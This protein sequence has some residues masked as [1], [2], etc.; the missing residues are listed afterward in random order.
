MT[1]IEA[2]NVT[3]YCKPSTLENGIPQSSAFE[4]RSDEKYLSVY[5]LEFFGNETEV[6]NIRQVKTYMEQRRFT[7]K[8]NGSFAILN[9]QQSKEYIYEEISSDIFYREENLP[10]CGIYHDADD[11]LIAEL[12]A[13]CVQNNYP[14]KNIGDAKQ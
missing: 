8:T 5:L 11:L 14:V 3:R 13:E 12:L 6:E 7:C 1:N 9:I 2:G 4:R 10:H